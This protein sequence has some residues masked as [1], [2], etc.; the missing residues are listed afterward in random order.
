MNIAIIIAG[1]SG[2]RFGA[3]IPK[4]FVTVNNEPVICYTL[5]IFQDAKCIDKIVVVC[6]EEWE[7]YI[8]TLKSTH[9]FCKLTDVVKSGDTR[10]NS[11]YN[12]IL[13][14]CSQC[15]KQDTLIIHDAVRPCITEELLE[16][17]INMARLHGAALATAPCFDTMFTSSN[18]K[19]AEGFYPREKLFKGQ[20]PVSI[21]AELAAECYQKAF[22]CQLYT[23]S[24]AVLLLQLGKK[25]ALS[26]GSQQNIKITTK[27]D[28]KI[29]DNPDFK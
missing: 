20:T 6:T 22:G 2:N 29:L 27:E 24:P 16:N 17:N 25:I 18:G 3:N 12:G 19:F 9:N 21:K 13:F 8:R 7:E 4:Q 1:G 26:K 11:I 28:L 23:D 15:D 14:C 10:F 5:R